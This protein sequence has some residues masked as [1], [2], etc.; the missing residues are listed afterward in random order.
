MVWVMNAPFRQTLTDRELRW[1]RHIAVHGPQ[2][3]EFLLAVCADTHRCRDT[4]LRT[5][6]RLRENGYL[7]LP[8]QQKQ[9]AKADFNPFVYDLT[10]QAAFY[11]KGIGDPET[12][13]PTGH[14]W[15]G[16]LTS[17]I[18]S[19][20]EIETAKRGRRY[21][22]AHKILSRNDTTLPIPLGQKKI[23]PDQ[24]FAIDYGG[25]FRSFVLETDRGTEP[26]RSETA[27]KSL[28]SMLCS[29]AELWAKDGAR[30]HY[31]LK[32]PLLILMAF[33]NPVRAA[34]C[35]ELVATRTPE[36]APFVLVQTVPSGFPKIAN[37]ATIASGSWRRSR[38]DT[39][40][41]ISSAP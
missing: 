20:I 19:A 38:F 1:L 37:V 33:T 7:R 3:S 26:V 5:L 22:P 16:F 6:Q 29:Y 10:K 23:I 39:V 13:P 25:S 35:L 28:E 8:P 34:R 9:I 12:V 41:L 40:S 11:L 17:T 24:L 30:R 18:T 31:G 14:W 15:H 4:G 2:S 27:R 32:S 36:L 21:I